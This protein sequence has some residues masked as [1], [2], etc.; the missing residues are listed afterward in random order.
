[1][2]AG[3]LSFISQRQ[4]ACIGSYV[5][6]AVAACCCK[7][8]A[9]LYRGLRDHP[10]PAPPPRWEEGAMGEVGPCFCPSEE[11]GGRR[12]AVAAIVVLTVFGLR[13]RRLSWS[14]TGFC[15]RLEGMTVQKRV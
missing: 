8:E 9:L 6:G 13:Q 2:P 5:A 4:Q 14:T 11:G 10:P 15:S 3:I 1:M 7:Q 12:A